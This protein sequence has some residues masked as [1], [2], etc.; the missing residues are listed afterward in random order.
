MNFISSGAA[1]GAIGYDEY[2]YALGDYPVAKVNTARVLHLPTQYNVAVALTAAVINT[3]KSPRTTCC[4]TSTTCTS[5]DNRTYPLSSY[6]YMVLPVSG[7]DRRA[8]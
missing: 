7:G 5:T 6:S 1:N 3:D 2:S 4:R 8:R